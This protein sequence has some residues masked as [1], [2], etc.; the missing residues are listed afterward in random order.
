M[1]TTRGAEKRANAAAA[2]LIT[3]SQ[4]VATPLQQPPPQAVAIP[5]QQPPS[6][7]VAIPLQ[8]PPQIQHIINYVPREKEVDNCGSY[9][10]VVD[11]QILNAKSK[12]VPKSIARVNGC[13]FQ[14]VIK[15]TNA[16]GS[17][18]VNNRTTGPPVDLNTSQ[19]ISNYTNNRVNWMCENYLEY[20]EIINGLVK[21]GDGD[22]FASGPIARYS[23]KNKPI[24]DDAKEISQG[25]IIHIGLAVF[26]PNSP[27]LDSVKSLPW[28]LDDRLPANGLPYL[29]LLRNE[30]LWQDI[31]LNKTSGIYKH[32]VRHVWKFIQ[33]VDLDVESDKE[34]IFFDSVVEIPDISDAIELANDTFNSKILTE[35]RQHAADSLNH[36]ISRPG[37]GKHKRYKNI[38]QKYKNT[39]KKIKQKHTKKN[40]TKKHKKYYKK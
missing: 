24:I 17:N 12:S 37:G 27:F 16:I 31:L 14:L 34:R 30:G 5:L 28:D 20:F 9:R 40:K 8:Q 36:L 19:N 38:K 4:T 25:T 6:Q 15:E 11:F 13:I 33:K 29:P 7:A 39:Q 2:A 10:V 22:A 3:T 32:E 35:S 18:F 23:S 21:K 1:A 26:V